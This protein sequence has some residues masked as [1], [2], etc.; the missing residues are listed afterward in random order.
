MPTDQAP[1]GGA[2]AP[3]HSAGSVRSGLAL[4]SALIG[5]LFLSITFSRPIFPLLASELGASKGLIG[6]LTSL[7]YVLPLVIV[8]PAGALLGRLGMRS[9]A[10]FGSVCLVLGNAAYALSAGFGPLAAARVLIGLAHVVVLVAVQA[11]VA[12]L[13]R[14]G[15]QDRNFAT[16]FFFSGIG[17]LAGPV[18]AGLLTREVGMRFTFWVAAVVGILPVVLSFGLPGVLTKQ[19]VAP[20]AT[21]QRSPG[22]GRF[23]FALVGRLLRIPGVQ[24]GV[25]ASLIMLL[26]E[27]ARESYYPLY[28]SEVGFDEVAI[29]MLLSVHALFSILIQP[30]AGSL[31]ARYGRTRVLSWAMTC[32]FLGHLAVPLVRGFGPMAA[33]VALAGLAMGANQPPSMACVA[34]AAPR[35]LR[36]LAMAVRLA[37]NRVGLLAS[38][39]IAGVVV[40]AWGLPAYFYVSAG[41]LMGGG[42]L[43]SALSRRTGL[44][45][46]VALDA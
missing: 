40:T 33:A 46:T 19:Q 2:S 7:S 41:M 20:S 35:E 10:V 16:I 22:D 37:G 6:G 23:S 24:L 39:I 26:A 18:I 3:E 25:G 12:E 43:M 11:Y 45:R 34:D 38:P 21:E 4:S 15:Q 14:G 29:G 28:A 8:I 32:G 5:L 13:G 1:A 31:A 30:F 44:D 42:A 27:G 17:Q 36:G 9:L